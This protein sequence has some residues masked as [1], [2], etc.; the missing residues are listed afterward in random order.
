MNTLDAPTMRLPV[1]LET[2]VAPPMSSKIAP[3]VMLTGGAKAII[4]STTALMAQDAITM[5]RRALLSYAVLLGGVLAALGPLLVCLGV[6]VV[7]WFLADAVPAR[8]EVRLVDVADA[9][10]AVD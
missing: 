3:K 2:N 4:T 5:G 7:G 1:T 6:G 9:P 8:P 10:T